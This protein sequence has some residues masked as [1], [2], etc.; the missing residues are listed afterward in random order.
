[1]HRD[2]FTEK[3]VR[4]IATIESRSLPVKVRQLYVF[5]SYSRGAIE[6]GDLDLI[7]VHNPPSRR[8][9]KR[10][11]AGLEQQGLQ[12]P[13][14][15]DRA[16][17]RYEAELRRP[18]RRPGERV[19]VIF[20]NDLKEAVGD[21]SRIKADD[22]ILI[23]SRWDWRANWKARL[24]AVVP[25]ESARRAPRNH[26]IP[27]ARLDCSVGEMEA[28]VRM[29]E[30]QRLILTRIAVSPGSL[31]LDEY[32]ADL[33]AWWIDCKAMGKK[34]LEALPYAMSW[35]QL[36]GQRCENLGRTQIRSSD[37]TCQVEIGKPSLAEMV[38]EFQNDG[39]LKRQC[40]IPHFKARSANELLVFERGPR[41]DEFR[42][43]DPDFD[44]FGWA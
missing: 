27:L 20:V 9:M 10:I 24:A 23:W 37:R 39:Q 14:V 1:M 29:I 26:L 16:Y 44:Y 8:Y 21:G 40:L 36:H 38:R 34:S 32:H 43:G 30:Q 17:R 4:I 35:F 42:S 12:W 33:L 18:I 11:R 3:L 2:R 13:E 19:Q 28:V 22:P 6:P 31:D 41:W 25:N 15:S 7:L 5:G